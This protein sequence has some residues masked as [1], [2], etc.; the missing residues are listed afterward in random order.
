MP[1]DLLRL[2]EAAALCRVSDDTIR[3]WA[4]QGRFTLYRLGP[5]TH[6]VSRADIEALLG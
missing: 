2:R 1:N 6:R 5:K 4:D 3:N